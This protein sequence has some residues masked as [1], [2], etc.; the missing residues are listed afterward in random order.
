MENKNMRICL[1][2]SANRFEKAERDRYL[3]AQQQDYTWVHAPGQPAFC[4]GLPPGEEFTKTKSAYMAMDFVES[5]ADLALA[6]IIRLFKHNDTV[7]SFKRYYPLRQIPAVAG[8]W[9][10]DE[11][12]A[13]QRL[14]GINPVLIRLAT[15]IPEKFPVTDEDVKGIIPECFNLEHLLAEQ[16]LFLLDYEILHGL[17][18]LLGRFCVAPIA[19]FWKN[20][21]GQLMPLAIQLGQSP[22]E[23]PVIFT[24][25]DEKWTWLM[26]RSFVQSADGTYHEVVAHLTRTHLAMETFWVAACRAFAPQHPLHVLL[27]PHFTGTVEI[28]HE[29]RKTLIAPGGP[30]DETI[31]IGAEGSL[32]AVGLEYDRWT[33]A[34]TN[35]VTDLENRGLL[36]EEVLPGYH[37]RED[38]LKLFTAI[39]QYVNDLLR[40]YYPDDE[41]VK[42]DIELQS[43]GRELVSK[44]GGRVKGLP[45]GKNGSIETFDAL[46]AIV[47][48]VIFICSVEH[49]AVNNGQYAQLGWIPNT[50]GAMY[51]PP[52]TDHSP[53][54]E[55]NLVY[56]LPGAHAVGQQ[57]TLVHLLSS[58]TLTPLGMYPPDF[59][60]GVMPARNAI[61]RFRGRLD[62][63]GREIEQRNKEL[64]V[65]YLYLQPWNIGRSIA[66]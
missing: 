6:S 18:P 31:A 14:D 54:D 52:P 12:F 48:Q 35:P 42:S 13:R 34:N 22:A 9:M 47:A 53:R 55:A 27:K 61:D 45:V 37:Y 5:V 66:I 56:A 23:A 51:L 58:K 25:K 40:V 32:T 59:F 2:D 15:E 43:W 30:I 17:Q 62:D 38:A 21:L 44:K 65:P 4:K 41:T 19:L 64:E 16:R 49:S 26:A 63:I 3:F 24:P 46:H 60:N 50:P 39:K 28:N 7:A 10:E 20:D 36:S 11:E 8:R 1:P 33:F 57:L 29:A